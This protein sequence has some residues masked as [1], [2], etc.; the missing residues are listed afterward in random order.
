MV[1]KKCSED[2][3]ERVRGQGGFELASIQPRVSR[4][5]LCAEAK[6]WAMGI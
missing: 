5:P 4:P 1:G 3:G 2:I 6:P